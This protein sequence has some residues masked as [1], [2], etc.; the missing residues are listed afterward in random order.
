MATFRFL[1]AIPREVGFSSTVLQELP[2]YIDAMIGNGNLPG[3]VTML[4][5]G[6]KILLSSVS[7]YEDT[8]LK[9]PLRHDSIFPLFSMSK[10]LTAVG[11][12]L[13]YDEGRWNLDDPVSRYLPEFKDIATLP[14]SASTREPTILE[15][16]THTAGFSFGRTPEEM[17]SFIQKINWSTARSLSE[18]VRR[19]AV[20]P[21]TY[22]PGTDWQYSVA[23]DLQAEIIERLTGE[24]FDLFMARRVFEPLGMY[25][26][27][28]QLTHEQSRRLVRCHVL[29]VETGRLRGARADER[30]ESIFPMGGTSFKSTALDYARFARMLL[31]R[32][33]LG[34]V[35]VLSETSV[36]LMLANHLSDEFLETPHSVM[37]YTIGRGNGHGMNGMVCVDPERA[38]R[39]VG[40]GTYE[41]GGAYSTWFWLDPENDILFVGMANR[42]RSRTDMRPLDVVSQEIV[43]RAMARP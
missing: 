32:G 30:M 31:N 7:G 9:T 26:T 37:H 10:P 15:I 29:D 4:M 20:L 13:L 18:L 27:A 6:D 17:L 23:T 3:A 25:D 5:R 34:D 43:Y 38:R 21:L 41:W 2:S 8:D 11:M 24:R 16:F 1:P 14:G 39:P 42:Q 12:L 35:R 22:E 40:K 33:T 36:K 19:Y 28:F